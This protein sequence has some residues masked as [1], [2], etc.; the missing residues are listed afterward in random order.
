MNSKCRAL[1]DF[2][3]NLILSQSERR[4]AKLNIRSLSVI[5]KRQLCLDLYSRGM[6]VHTIYSIFEC[7]QEHFVQL[8]IEENIKRCANCG[9]IKTRD[10]FSKHSGFDGLYSRC[11][12]CAR[13]YNQSDTAKLNRKK[14]NQTEDK[15]EKNRN[16]QSRR[17]LDPLVRLN[18]NFSSLMARSLKK[19]A[20]SKN[21]NHWENLV[22]YSIQD[23]KEH[24]QSQFKPGMNWDNYGQW[25]VDH[26]YP[27]SKF[28]I[29]ALG[30]EEFKKCWSLT[31]LQPLW[32]LDNLTKS[33][34]I[35][36]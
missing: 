5:E 34:K 15:K 27:K 23:L 10:N 4:V 36:R 16:Y 31:N 14:R 6:N 9:C 32:A 19:K 7:T 22:G 17:K 33:D 8:L 29:E 11:N 28:N 12:D 24:L 2:I 3:M 25:H 1:K 35:F 26:I 20:V 30:D 21:F 18:S 13:E